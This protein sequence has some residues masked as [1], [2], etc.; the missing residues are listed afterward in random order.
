MM[1][2]HGRWPFLEFA[3][4]STVFI[5]TGRGTGV[6]VKF[7]GGNMKRPLLIA[8]LLL[9]ALSAAPACTVKQ[10]PESSANKVV[11]KTDTVSSSFRPPI[12]NKSCPE[13]YL[14]G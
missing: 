14:F 5:F 9:I 10:R 7:I 6:A 1:L 3:R 11:M 2:V 8:I 12:F 4:D 13:M